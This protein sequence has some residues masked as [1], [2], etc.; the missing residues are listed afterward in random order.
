[1]E[2][3]FGI[4]VAELFFIAIVALIVLGPERLP[5]TLREIA[6]YWGYVRNLS[7]ELMSQFSDELE[8]LDEI[9]PRKIFNEITQQPYDVKEIKAKPG[10]TA[11]TTAAKPVTTP[12]PATPAKTVAATKPTPAT[13]TASTAKTKPVAADKP[14]SPPKRTNSNV[15]VFT[16]PENQI[17][18]PSTDKGNGEMLPV[19]QKLVPTT[20][21]VSE[22][23][24][25]AEI[26][27]VGATNLNGKAGSQPEAG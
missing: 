10:V 18:P 22:N 15:Q 6:K 12:K 16:A 2:S 25:I 23:L 4:G 21:A 1:M 14:V 27:A 26:A 17:L 20:E 19:P 3:F 13:S 8:A 7:R 5:S 11:K 24:R 9:N